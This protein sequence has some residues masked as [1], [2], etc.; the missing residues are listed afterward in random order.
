MD[1]LQETAE[2]LRK[3]REKLNRINVFPV[4]DGD[5]GNNLLA[6]L[7]SSLQ[8]ARSTGDHR[9]SSVVEVASRNAAGGSCGSSGAIFAQILKGWASALCRNDHAG[10]DDLAKAFQEGA[11]KAYEAVARPVEGT[12][13]TVAR[14]AARAAV[15]AASTSGNVEQTLLAAYNQA[16]ET[17]NQTPY[18]LESLGRRG[19]IDAGGWGLLLFLGSLLKAMNIEVASNRVEHPGAVVFDEYNGSLI[20]HPYDLEFAVYLPNSVKIKTMLDGEGAELV[21]R[22][23][24]SSCLVHI[25]TAYPVRV[26]EK[27]AAMG[28][29][30]NVFIRDMRAQFSRRQETAPNKDLTLVALGD[31]PGFLGLFAAAGAEAAFS[32]HMV[33]RLLNLVDEISS[34][35][36]LILSPIKLT[37]QAPKTSVLVIEE[38]PRILSALL[39]YCEQ[40]EVIS[41]S[42][43]PANSLSRD[44]GQDEAVTD[45]LKELCGA[46]AYPRTARFTKHN[47]IYR[48]L[49]NRREIAAGALGEAFRRAVSALQPSPGEVISIYYGHP[50]YRSA[51]ARFAEPLHTSYPETG[52]ELQYG[53]QE[54]PLIISVE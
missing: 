9:L 28:Q 23:S 8:G 54:H 52:I 3:N 30:S 35:N 13:L 36:L 43:D 45:A 37:F 50:H 19:V 32:A 17:L 5:T 40:S 47:H 42:R 29:V 7:E 4:P 14:E 24:P 1:A 44:N 31:S 10:A 21:I 34:E 48:V 22:D 25:H 18:I 38:E 26:L 2:Q 46:A 15:E 27:A 49:V 12:I 33:Q 6:T 16:V 20:D 39:Y 53:G 11:S 51:V 41:P